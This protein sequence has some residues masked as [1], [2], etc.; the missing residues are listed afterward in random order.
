M[1]M[2]SSRYYESLNLVKY[3]IIYSTYHGLTPVVEYWLEREIAQCAGGGEGGGGIVTPLFNMFPLYN[4]QIKD[5]CIQT[6]CR[7]IDINTEY[8][9][10]VTKLSD[11]S[12][13]SE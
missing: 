6:G 3:F 12:E 5:R 8:P 7:E 10:R 9:R 13:I 2:F 1:F 11:C 4:I